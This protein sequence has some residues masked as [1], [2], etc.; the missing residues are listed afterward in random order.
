MML[1]K[2]QWQEIEKS[3]SHPYGF[4]KLKCDGYVINAVVEKYKGLKYCLVVYVDGVFE[5]KWMDGKDERALKFHCKRRSYA[6]A[7]SKRAEAL[8]EI[9]RRSLNKELKNFYQKW[10]DKYIDTWMPFWP[11]AKSFCR[12]IRKTCQSIEFIN[13]DAD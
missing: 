7:G 3:L 4:V 1:S 12:H 13:R 10:L 6:L 2:D 9:K 11:N 8:K 5:G